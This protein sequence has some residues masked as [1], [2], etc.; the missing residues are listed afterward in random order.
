MIRL[1]IFGAAAL[2]LAFLII[3]NSQTRKPWPTNNRLRVTETETGSHTPSTPRVRFRCAKDSSTATLIL[4]VRNNGPDRLSAG[5]TVYYYYRTPDSDMSIT[6]SHLLAARLDKG[7]IFSIKLG[8]NAQT[9]ITEC[10][11]SLR[12]FTPTART[13]TKKAS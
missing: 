2:A 7:G 5:T 13:A 10:G 12:R 9:R 4:D 11:C 3:A 6:G 8:D 1:S